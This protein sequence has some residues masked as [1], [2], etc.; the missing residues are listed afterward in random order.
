MN[1]A[2]FSRLA[3]LGTVSALLPLTSAHAVVLEQKWEP[4]QK[5]AYQ[6]EI[7]G[8]VNVLVPANAPIIIAG[9]PI[10]AEVSGIGTTELRTLKVDPKGVGTVQVSVPKHQPTGTADSRHALLIQ[11]QIPGRREPRSSRCN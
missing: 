6:T 4:G 5:L 1:K 3:A 9:V 7:S 8:T 10:E 2:V 11:G